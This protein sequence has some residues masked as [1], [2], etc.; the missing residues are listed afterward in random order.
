MSKDISDIL[1]DWDYNPHKS[2]RKIVGEQGERIIQVRVDNAAFQGI[3]QMQLDGR[4][5]GRQPH[6]YEFVLD[7]HLEALKRWREAHQGDK[8]FQLSSAECAELFDESLRVYNRY[9]FLLQLQESQ[10]GPVK[11]LQKKFT[12]IGKHKGFII[13][14]DH[15][16]EQKTRW[17]LKEYL[18][19]RV[20]TV[21]VFQAKVLYELRKDIEP[22]INAIVES[23]E[24][25]Y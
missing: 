8:G 23:L 11:V 16:Q 7:Y 15:F 21:Y 3:L 13:S 25:I 6:G 24:F 12:S 18:L 10:S 20:N 19:P 9:V 2:Y 4:P 14:L 5:D 1:R 22:K 17:L